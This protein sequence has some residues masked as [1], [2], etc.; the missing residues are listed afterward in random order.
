MGFVIYCV[1]GG[2]VT[3]GIL[4]YNAMKLFL[5]PVFLFSVSWALCHQLT[6][7]ISFTF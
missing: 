5:Y 2:G 3:F 7:I 1:I 4:L 6:I